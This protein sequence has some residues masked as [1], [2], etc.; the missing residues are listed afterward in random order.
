[1]HCFKSREGSLI[2]TLSSLN[3]SSWTEGKSLLIITITPMNCN[4]SNQG[5]VHWS[6][7]CLPEL[8]FE[9]RDEAFIG[10]NLSLKCTAT[11]LNQGRSLLILHSLLNPVPIDIHEDTVANLPRKCTYNLWTH[12]WGYGRMQLN[13]LHKLN[14]PK[15][16][17]LFVLTYAYKEAISKI[18]ISSHKGKW[19]LHG[20]QVDLKK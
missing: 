1:M 19:F 10:Y 2:V 5:R 13:Q 17:F 4:T 6:L 18:C 15:F 3:T 14:V 20:S 12:C 7:H 8:C 16:R 11:D 9:W